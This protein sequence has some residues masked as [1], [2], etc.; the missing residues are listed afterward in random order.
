MP[1]NAEGLVQTTILTNLRGEGEEGHA[2]E[3]KWYIFSVV[4]ENFLLAI[5]VK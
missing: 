4:L 1:S 3:R 5:S 2:G